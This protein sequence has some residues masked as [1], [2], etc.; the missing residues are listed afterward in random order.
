MELMHHYSDHVVNT[1]LAASENIQRLWKTTIPQQA[2]QHAMLLHGLLALSALSL[3]YMRPAES[4]KYLSLCDKHQTI[5]IAGYRTVLNGE[6][7]PHNAHALFALASTISISSMAR[8]GARASAQPAPRF[9][10]LDEIAEMFL[11]TRS[12]ECQ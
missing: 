7:T 1:P 3:A 8:A 12:V 5:A 6:I 9:I 4:A 11:L 10:S 2:L